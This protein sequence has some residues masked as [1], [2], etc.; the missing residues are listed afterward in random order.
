MAQAARSAGGTGWSR[1][2]PPISISDSTINGWLNRKAVPT[3]RK[4]ERYLTAM[5]AYLQGRVGS[6]TRYRPLPPGE[7]G[8]LLSAAQAERAAGRQ[9]GRPHRATGPARGVGAIEGALAADVEVSEAMSGP[10]PQ[11]L[12]G[13]DRELTVLAGL[14]TGVAAG[15]GSVV[16]IEGEP[17]IGKSALVRAALAGAVGLGCRVFWGSGD[18]LGQ[19]L[20]FHPLL[21][22]L[23]VREPSANP[24]RNTIVRLLRGEVTADYRLRGRAGTGRPGCS[25]PRSAIR[26]P[27]GRCCVPGRW[28][29]Q[30]PNSLVPM[31]MTG[32]GPPLPVRRRSTPSSGRPLMAR[33][34]RPGC[35]LARGDSNSYDL[36]NRKASCR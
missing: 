19:T 7:W 12:L 23:H 17:G 30:R 25:R 8:R 16:L 31:R 28:R 35:E 4:N 32:P 33:G 22:G 6:G 36:L 20:P 14:V 34:C 21:D 3:G 11:M 2:H 27:D 26:A 13:R 29:R 9:Q 18:E 1:Q 10:G 24:R 15:R 5:V